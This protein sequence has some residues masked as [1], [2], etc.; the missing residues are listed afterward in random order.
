MRVRVY[1]INI[2]EQYNTHIFGARHSEPH[3]T[4]VP[5]N[6]NA[7]Q[8]PTFYVRRTY[9]RCHIITFS[10]YGLPNLPRGSFTLFHTHIYYNKYNFGRRILRGKWRD[11]GDGDR[12]AD[13]VTCAKRAFQTSTPTRHPQKRKAK[14][15]GTFP[16]K[17]KGENTPR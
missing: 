6:S 4:R 12:N 2:C 14:V 16:K 7:L 13:Q 11:G 3:R 5:R 1:L 15:F 10:T 8:S 9:Y 17:Y